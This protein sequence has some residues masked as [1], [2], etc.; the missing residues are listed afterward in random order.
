MTRWGSCIA[1]L[2][3]VVGSRNLNQDLTAV[4]EAVTRWASCI[5]DPGQGC[6]TAETQILQSRCN[7][8]KALTS[9]GEA[10]TR[11]ASA[12]TPHRC[13]M[14]SLLLPAQYATPAWQTRCQYAALQAV[15]TRYLPA[16]HCRSIVVPDVQHA[17]LSALYIRQAPDADGCVR[18]AAATCEQ[19]AAFGGREPAGPPRRGC[20][21]VRAFSMPEPISGS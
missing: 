1:V 2:D 21:R 19:L 4:G 11:W 6:R 3:R 13:R 7:V 20:R 9:V 5:S 14:G 8:S 10:V 16:A 17:K 18:T 12:P 15:S